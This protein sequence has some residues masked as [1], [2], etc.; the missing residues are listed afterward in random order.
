MKT[1]AKRGSLL[2]ANGFLRFIVVFKVFNLFMRVKFTHR[3][4]KVHLHLLSERKCRH[5]IIS[6]IKKHQSHDWQKRLD[7]ALINSINVKTQQKLLQ[8]EKLKCLAR[9][10]CSCIHVSSFKVLHYILPYQ[11]CCTRC[12]N[13]LFQV[14]NKHKM[15]WHQFCREKLWHESEMIYQQSLIAVRSQMIHSFL[16]RKNLKVMLF[17]WNYSIT[18]SIQTSCHWFF[19]WFSLNSMDFSHVNKYLLPWR[20]IVIQ[21]V[22]KNGSKTLRKRQESLIKYE[23]EMPLKKA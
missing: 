21:C 17:T 1:I 20:S 12:C 4:R 16:C 10:S 19:K 2:S 18:Y 9:K 15:T 22:S 8:L 6:N 14:A 5:V 3:Y 23:T 7:R 13:W 11:T